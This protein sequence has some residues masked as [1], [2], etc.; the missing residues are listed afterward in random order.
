MEIW[1][2]ELVNKLPQNILPRIDILEVVNLANLSL[3]QI[4]FVILC[5]LKFCPAILLLSI[6]YSMEM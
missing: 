5:P 3:I 1:L 4:S 2:H 6:F